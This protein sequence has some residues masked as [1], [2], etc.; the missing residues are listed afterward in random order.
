N[1]VTADILS[2]FTEFPQGAMEQA[3]VIEP[4]TS[5][6]GVRGEK[7]DEMV[8]PAAV[9]EPWKEVESV[10]EEPFVEKTAESVD[11]ISEEP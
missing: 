2:I 11:F 9:Q 3:P 10:S 7:A 5:P 8:T 1:T 6:V 4:V